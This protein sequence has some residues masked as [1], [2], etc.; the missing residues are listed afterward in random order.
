MRLSQVCLVPNIF[1]QRVV[2]KQLAEATVVVFDRHEG[3]NGVRQE[4]I[5]VPA[6]D[7]VP[8]EEKRQPHVQD[9]Q[10]YPQR[11]QNLALRHVKREEQHYVLQIIGQRAQF[12]VVFAH[13][14]T[15]LMFC[16]VYFTSISTR[17]SLYQL[18]NASRWRYS[19][20]TWASTD[21]IVLKVS[22]CQGSM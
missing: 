3:V 15:F 13:I 21:F 16:E 9:V 6:P 7:F 22:Y 12:Y 11:R 14:H 1:V 10:N 5:V 19:A 17:K 4:N 2:I 20:I 18:I 8:K